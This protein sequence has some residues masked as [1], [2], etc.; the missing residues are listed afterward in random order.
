MVATAVQAGGTRVK[1]AAQLSPYVAGCADFD[2]AGWPPVRHR[3]LPDETLLLVVSCGEPLIVRRPDH[4]DLKVA[5][6][7]AGLRTG[8]VDIIHDGTQR[9]VQLELT[10]RGA[11]ALLGL[12]AAALA[13]GVWPLD[14][15]AGCRGSEL[16]GRLA[17]AP[18]PAERASVI[19]AVLSGWVGDDDRFPAAV[20]AFWRRLLATA[21]S[22]PVA[23]IA[24]ELG[25]GRRHLGQLVRT[26]IGLSPK[27]AARILRFGRAGRL[28][29]SG[30]AGSL[31]DTAVTC[32]Y[33]DQAHL[34]NDWKRLAGCTPGQWMAEELPFLQDQDSAAST[35]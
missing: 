29:R 11:R 20:D 25:L 8:P 12:P 5:A 2:M 35:D 28:L 30:H 7:I 17:G 26:E 33:F 16:T 34:T 27:T 22:A 9:G 14:E 15:V 3:G 21:G 10:P 24:R 4:P 6:S 23:S 18:G 31:A 32:G 13:L 19:N 1:L